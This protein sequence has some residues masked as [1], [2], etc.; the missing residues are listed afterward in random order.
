MIIAPLSASD[1]PVI[2]MRPKM[3]TRRI[4]HGFPWAYANEVVADRRTKALAPGTLAVLEDEH[5]N[6][7]A[8]V[9]VNPA[10]KIIARVV[11]A[12]IN[13]QVDTDWFA[14]RLTRALALRTRLFDAPFYRLI[15]AEADGLPGVVRPFRGCAGDPTECCMGRCAHRYAGRGGN[16][17]H[18]RQHSDQERRRARTQP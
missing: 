14:A 4:R 6:Q 3:D 7:M 9:A 15:H 10:S 5:R 17:R 11:D 2:R 18:R 12:D 16:G 13:A 1:R 8:L